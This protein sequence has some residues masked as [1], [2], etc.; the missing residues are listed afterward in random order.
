MQTCFSVSPSLCHCLLKLD[1]LGNKA[2]DIV[3]KPQK[4]FEFKPLV[5]TKP[6]TFIKTM[7]S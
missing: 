3:Q 5:P 1:V 6:V 2:Q 7:G 4:F